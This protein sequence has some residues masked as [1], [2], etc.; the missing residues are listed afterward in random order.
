MI[1][2]IFI[3]DMLYK[4]IKILIFIPSI[5]PYY[6]LPLKGLILFS[7]YPISKT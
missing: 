3:D 5:V 4:V 7:T 1:Q 2:L 6:L